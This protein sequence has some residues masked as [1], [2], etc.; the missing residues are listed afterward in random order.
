MSKLDRCLFFFFQGAN[1]LLTDK[2]DIK[3]GKLPSFFSE[4]KLLVAG[5]WW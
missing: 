2:G 1:I 4:V 5:K 3:L